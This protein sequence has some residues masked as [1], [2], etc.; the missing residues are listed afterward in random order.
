MNGNTENLAAINTATESR[1]AHNRI[2]DEYQD[3]LT[4]AG[5]KLKELILDRAAHDR[6]ICL[7]ELR[8]LVRYAYPEGA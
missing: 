6:A 2:I 7:P 5:P 3:A 1:R 4:G 8:D